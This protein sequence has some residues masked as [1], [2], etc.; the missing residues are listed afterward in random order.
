MRRIRGVGSGGIAALNHR[1][2][3][4]MPP[5]SGWG[6]DRNIG[7]VQF[8]QPLR[9]AFTRFLLDRSARTDKNHCRMR[10]GEASVYFTSVQME[11]LF[12]CAFD[13][14]LAERH[15]EFVSKAR[16][17]RETGYG[18]KHL[19]YFYPFRP[20]A[21]YYPYGALSFDFVPRL[22]AGKIRIRKEKRHTRVHLVV[23]HMG[24][25]TANSIDRDAATAK[26]RCSDLQAIIFDAIGKELDTVGSLASALELLV[27]EKAT[28]R[29]GFYN[30]PETAL[31]YAFTLAKL[32]RKQEA[33]SELE[34]LFGKSPYY[35][36]Q[37][38]V[39]LRESLSQACVER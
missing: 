8:F 34:S 3:A 26:Q 31:S 22:E 25:G 28:S 21:A 14:L 10:F 37:T 27:Q 39:A 36:L 38:H 35:P 1:L 15:F 4:W 9:V 13:P 30:T 16:W 7:G 2:L 29:L 32:G 12:R 19:F 23:T 17:V 11:E 18:F 5:A 24:T 33:E 6:N 20:G